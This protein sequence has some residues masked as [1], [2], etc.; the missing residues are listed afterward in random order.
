MNVQQALQLRGTKMNMGK[1]PKG[2]TMEHT[3]VGDT[4][5]TKIKKNG[6]LQTTVTRKGTF[7]RDDQNGYSLNGMG[8]KT[9]F[10]YPTDQKIHRKGKFVND[11]L[12]DDKGV[13]TISQRGSKTIYKGKFE[14]D[15]PVLRNNNK[16][17]FDFNT[18]T[19]IYDDGLTYQGQLNE[20]LQRHGSGVMKLKRGFT[21]KCEWEFGEYKP[22]TMCEYYDSI[23]K[24]SLGKAY[25]L[26]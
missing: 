26:P 15:F 16:Y 10:D 8:E 2:I 22:N 12:S 5:T 17:P 9:T 23:D 18:F 25:P 7:V 1:K 4:I 11:Q 21:A 3:R 20:K 13:M 19:V 14:N 24:K 6:I